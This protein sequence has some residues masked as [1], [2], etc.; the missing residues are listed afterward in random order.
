MQLGIYQSDQVIILPLINRYA[1][2][3]GLRKRRPEM[4]LVRTY[5]VTKQ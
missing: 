1:I 3:G 2:E 5:L 4:A